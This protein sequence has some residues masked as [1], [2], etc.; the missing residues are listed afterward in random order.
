VIVIFYACDLLI[1]FSCFILDF[2][3]FLLCVDV[4]YMYQNSSLSDALF[5]VVQIVFLL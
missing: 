2:A 4:K 3:R 1:F 5:H